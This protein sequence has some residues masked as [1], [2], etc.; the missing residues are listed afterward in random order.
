MRRVTMVPTGVPVGFQVGSLRKATG[1]ILSTRPEP[2]TMEIKARSES[3][4]RKA[5]VSQLSSFLD[6]TR[7]TAEKKKRVKAIIVEVFPG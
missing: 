7:L 3:E 1:M 4:P 6:R 2:Q 5:E